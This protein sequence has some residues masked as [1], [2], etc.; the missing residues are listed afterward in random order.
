MLGGSSVLRDGLILPIPRSVP[1][2]FL[3]GLGP[4][5]FEG[6]Q[7]FTYDL[8]VPP[9]GHGWQSLAGVST[10]LKLSS[11]LPGTLGTRQG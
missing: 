7:A 4:A 6:I 2:T 11:A 1:T 3:W 10:G 9:R 5:L 8:W